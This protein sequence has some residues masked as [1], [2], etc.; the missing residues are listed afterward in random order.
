MV[1]SVAL[2]MAAAALAAAAGGTWWAPGSG[3]VDRRSVVVRAVVGAVIGLGAGLLAVRAIGAMTP[4]RAPPRLSIILLAVALGVLVAVGTVSRRPPLELPPVAE[5]VVSTTMHDDAATTD[6]RQA[7]S[8]TS[9][10]GQSTMTGSSV[11]ATS[12]VATSISTT[13]ADDDGLPWAAVLG[14]LLV[15]AALVL[16]VGRRRRAGDDALA[17]R[18]AALPAPTVEAAPVE[19]T[20][21]RSLEPLLHDPD[22]RIGVCAAYAV[23]LDAL[24]E[25]G[26]ARL[27]F[28]APGEHLDRCLAELPVDPAPLRTV[29]RLF[30]LARYSTYEVDDSARRRA[31]EALRAAEAE[32]GDHGVT[33]V[34][35]AGRRAWTTRR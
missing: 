25:V 10:A 13:T 34:Q 12:T 3:S 7:A 23:L 17:P 6:E 8:T 33:T 20:E 19:P 28:E 21:L 31:I 29:L 26:L 32:L 11:I 18:G 15:A 9:V 1:I 22:P 16:L 5:T 35:T 24:A 14:A 27:R 4:W 30:I 2:A